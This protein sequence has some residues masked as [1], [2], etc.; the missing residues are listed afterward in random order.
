[1]L[2]SKCSAPLTQ[3]AT[4]PGFTSFSCWTLGWA[5][6]EFEVSW[7]VIGDGH[8][9]SKIVFAPLMVHCN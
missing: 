6:W 7:P 8:G 4:G 5:G 2:D 1:M 9:K 3:L